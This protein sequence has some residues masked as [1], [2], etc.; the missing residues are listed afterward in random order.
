MVHQD[1]E[2]LLADGC[3]S[4]IVLFF[5]KADLNK[6]RNS[7]RSNSKTT[8]NAFDELEDFPETSV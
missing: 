7:S 3:L 2:V 6:I 5:L 8:L 4:K 1:I